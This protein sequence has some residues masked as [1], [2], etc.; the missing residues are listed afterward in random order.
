MYTI[1][2]QDHDQDNLNIIP[3][4]PGDEMP[5]FLDFEEVLANSIDWGIISSAEE[6]QTLVDGSNHIEAYFTSET[7]TE[8]T[9]N[10]L[11]GLDPDQPYTP[12]W[13]RN[14]FVYEV[15]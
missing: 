6:I 4:T 9:C 13:D 1:K 11:E 3:F 5:S 15:F 8:E 7:A 2:F 10:I 12:E 14:N